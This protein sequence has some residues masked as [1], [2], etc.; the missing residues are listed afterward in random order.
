MRILRGVP[1]P[2][3]M[4]VLGGTGLTAFFGV[5]D[6]LKPKPGDVAVV[7]GAAGATGSI[8]A[9]L[10]KIMGCKVIAIAGTKEKCD[11]LVKELGMDAGGLLGPFVW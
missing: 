6:I 9:Q 3:A 11:W 7:S 4:S 2:L 10:L 8:A 5:L 1:S